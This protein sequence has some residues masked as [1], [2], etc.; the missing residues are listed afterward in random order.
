MELLASMIKTHVE[1]G[2]KDDKSADSYLTEYESLV[3]R[4]RK[5]EDKYHAFLLENEKKRAQNIE[6]SRF[7][8]DFKQMNHLPLEF[9]E[10]PFHH[11]VSKI[12]ITK[13]G[14][15]EFHIKNGSNIKLTI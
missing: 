5:Y 6:L 4:Y 15:A 11:T 9:D 10:V 8:N 12:I 3:N 2:A 7:I 1:N 14:Y 13:D